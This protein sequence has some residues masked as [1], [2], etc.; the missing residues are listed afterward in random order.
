MSLHRPFLL[1]VI[2]TA[3]VTVCTSA[4]PPQP[5][6]PAWPPVTSTTRP[7][8]YWW[9]LG[10]AVDRENIAKELRRYHDAG[11][12]GVHLI[13]IYGAKG[14]ES[15]YISYL[16]PKWM[17]MLRFT[18]EEARRLD[19][20]VDMTL[21]TG[22]CFGGP[23]VPE[24]HS[25]LRATCKIIDVPAG[26]KLETRFAPG[27]VLALVAYDAKGKPTE[28]TARVDAKGQVTWKPAN[29]AWKVYAVLEK[30]SRVKVKRAA[31]GGEGFML[32]PFYGEAIENYLHRFDEAFDK[33]DGPKPRAIYHDS[34]EY[35]SEWSPDLFAEFEK[36]R[37]YRLQDHLPQ[38][39]G[40]GTDD[41]TAR[42]KCDYRETISDMMVENFMPAWTGWAAEHDMQSRNQAHGSPGNLLD[43]Y[44]AAS[45]P[46][47]E[48]FSRDREM[49]VCKFASS[50]AHVTGGRP[51]VSSETGTWLSEHF[52]ETLGD[53]KRLVDELFVSG[54]NHVFY[55]G[56]CY[57]PDE[58]AWPGWLF[59]AATEMNPRNSIWHDVPA[60]NAYITR[61]QSVLQDGQPDNDILLYWP[62]HDLWHNP[63][64][65][66][67]DAHRPSA[68][69]VEQAADW[70]N[71]TVVV[72]PRIH[73]RLHFGSA[74]PDKY[75][76]LPSQ[77]YRRVRR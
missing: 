25:G 18:I 44:G 62:I 75:N 48:M 66:S 72:E 51:L 36:R 77:G 67:A 28:I 7:W 58:A 41:T 11:L 42:V 64:R 22:W 56:T 39:F 3:C 55:H 52:T 8:T 10:S 17:E 49:L 4:A 69:L 73:V 15:R 53:M 71:S 46:E 20:D 65:N 34:Y 63:E 31:P 57:S 74:T 21:G 43:L 19:M 30:S 54:I 9:W 76:S 59:Y 16:S 23:N 37:G 32:N 13:P 26:G 14:Y 1:A 45:I 29:G 35:H 50:A 60:L 24:H 70:P 12:G 2:V 5:Q 40:S 68:R 27:T 33:Y 38:M 6:E 61:C 47:T